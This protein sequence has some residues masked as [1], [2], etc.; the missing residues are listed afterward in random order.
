MALTPEQVQELKNQLREQVK[1]LPEPQKSEGLK[2]IEEMSD[3]A[4]ELM[5]K[6][7]QSQA[8]DPENSPFRQIVNGKIPV[9]VLDHSKHAIAFLDNKPVSKGHIVIV[10]IVAAKTSKDLPA[11]A[12]SMAKKFCKK[13]ESKLKAQGAEIQTQFAFGEMIINVIPVYD[14]PVS[15]NS[16]RG[17]ASEEEL[18]QL[19]NILKIVK[20][21]KVIKLN[22]DG[23]PLPKRR[24][25]KEDN[26]IRLKRKIP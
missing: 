24:K 22:K 9:K 21:Q 17:E 26:V 11:P 18:I 23:K 13:I 3:E 4:V 2:Q 15:I 25:K 7:Q 10:P 16:P 14:K 8:S 12:L 19:W 5:L 6:Q 1:D 20:K